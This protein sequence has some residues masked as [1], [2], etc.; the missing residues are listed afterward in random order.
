MPHLHIIEVPWGEVFDPHQI[1]DAIQL[2]Q[3][4]VVEIV[5]GDTLATLLQPLQDAF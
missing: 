2:V 4:K 5:Q 1:E 3:P